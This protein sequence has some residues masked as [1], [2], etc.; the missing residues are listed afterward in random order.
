LGQ[1]LAG[2][3]P[4]A[5]RNVISGNQS[6]GLLLGF[7]AGSGG[8]LNYVTGNY[9]GTNAQ[10]SAALPNG[11]VGVDV[12]F[13]ESNITNNVISGNA[14]AGVLLGSVSALSLTTDNLIGTNAQ[15]NA[16]VPNLIGV[17]SMTGLGF[18]E[19]LSNVISGN[20]GVG[21]SFNG[22][23]GL[24]LANFIGT[25]KAGTV[26][27]GNGG[28][29][30]HI[31][32]ATVSIGTGGVGNT[33][34]FNGGN[35]ISISGNGSTGNAISANSIFSNGKLGIDLGNDGVTPND[36]GDADTGPNNLQNYPVLTAASVASGNTTVQGSF[37]SMANTKYRVEFFASASPDPSGFGEGQTFLGAQDVTTGNDGNA[38]INATFSATSPTGQNSITATATDPS[39]NTSEF[40]NAVQIP[41]GPSQLLNIA[42]RL[43]VLGGDNV[44][45]GGF[46]ITGSTLKKVMLRAIGPSLSS[47][48]VMGTLADPTLEL[49]QGA[50]T[51]AENDNWKINDASGQSQEAAIRA[52]TIPPSN[53]LESAIL[54]TLA[55]GAYSAVVIGKGGGTGIGVVE[56]YDLDQTVPSQLA[57]IASRGFIEAGN[58]VMIG[59]F[60][61]GPSTAANA[62]VVIRGIG[63]SL[64][65]AGVP[66]ALQ[67]PTLELHDGNGAKI[68]FNDNWQDD[69]GAAEIRANQLDPKDPRESALLRVLPPGAYSAIVAGS[70][71]T[72]GIGLVEIYNLQ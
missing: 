67:D 3:T 44:L 28:D 20:T 30:I 39:N 5:D 52:T 29:G 59:G 10:G 2:G 11:G 47:V 33:I 37:N 51:L 17:S 50:T 22:G 32:D 58:N 1:N 34:A 15:G 54:T 63:P 8:F 66:G 14:G 27:L 61:L 72:T 19:I 45:I 46:I 24:L 49:H 7:L 48:G 4:P 68:A 18:R 53:D 21:I 70:G 42:T 64:T 23:S 56:A 57:N 31:V 9:I 41:G 60:I 6:D 69:A 43:N 36:S 13:Q 65:A 40:S 62:K 26:A 25:N 71:N 38:T 35:G 55:P 16:A 12:F